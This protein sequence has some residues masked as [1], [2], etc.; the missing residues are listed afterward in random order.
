MT[1]ESMNS[2]EVLDKWHNL[3]LVISIEWYRHDDRRK[4]LNDKDILNYFGKY[5]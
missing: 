1:D 2:D 3:N 5:V 4:G